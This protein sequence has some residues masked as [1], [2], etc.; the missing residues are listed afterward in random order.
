M[1]DCEEALTE[2]QL[3]GFQVFDELVRIPLRRITLLFG[4]NSAG[5]SAIEDAL[6][7]FDDI[8]KFVD[9]NE[10]SKQIENSF[11]TFPR[12]RFSR[13]ERHWRK[14]QEEPMELADHLCIQ[15]SK[16][17]TVRSLPVITDT[18]INIGIKVV[19]KL[20]P[21]DDEDLKFMVY[22]D[23]E[24]LV[25]GKSLLLMEEFKR[26]GINLKHPRLQFLLLSIYQDEKYYTKI[27]HSFETSSNLISKMLSDKDGWVWIEGDNIR[28]DEQKRFDLDFFEYFTENREINLINFSELY[29]ALSDELISRLINTGNNF[30]AIVPASRKIPSERDL[31]FLI[32]E[33]S[34]ESLRGFYMDSYGASEYISL[35]ESLASYLVPTEDRKHNQASIAFNVNRMLTDYLFLERGYHLEMDYR[36]ILE[37]RQFEEICIDFDTWSP[38][39]FSLLVRIF[40]VDAQGR[41]FSFDEVG[42]GLGYVLPVLCE[43]SKSY[44]QLVMLQQPE[45]HLHPALQ[46]ALGDVLIDA[47]NNLSVRLSTVIAETHSEYLLLRIL[48]RIRNTQNGQITGNELCIT[49]E[50]VSVLYFDPKINGTTQVK[51]LRIS[52]DGE[53]L[54]RWP[55][56]FFSERDKELFDE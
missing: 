55:R 20:I 19:F 36:I 27:I 14:I 2:I 32:E 18:L 34:N 22:R 8:F 30:F 33:D 51:H 23:I 50:E 25:E 52:P 10:L 42:S 24:F 1:A 37:P 39:E 54:D 16:N 56:G 48:K 6:L 5:K 3:S 44:S 38:S 53:F 15:V 7:I 31:V 41:R 40:L 49:H 21:D 13:L 43:L 17:A 47:T 26:I 12:N 11:D 28:I 29:N 35:A 45:L 9:T 4:P 46:A